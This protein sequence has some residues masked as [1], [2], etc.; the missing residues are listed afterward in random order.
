MLAGRRDPNLSRMEPVV[1]S[2]SLQDRYDILGQ[3]GSGG[4]G[5]VFKA[6]D[7]ALRR[8]V[9]IK[10]FG[11]EFGPA[12]SNDERAWREAMT[13]ASIQHPNILT[14]FDFGTDAEG[15]YVITEFLEGESLDAIV[16]RGGPLHMKEFRELVRQTLEGLIAAHQIGLIHRDIKPQNI[17]VTQLASGAL[18]FKILDF[19]LAKIL[20]EPK[21]QTMAGNQTIVGSIFYISPEQLSRHPVDERSDL[22]A[23]GCVYYFAL[24]GTQ[25]FDGNSIT[26]IITSHVRN[27]VTPLHQ[28]RPDMQQPMCDWVMKFIQLLPEHRFQNAVEA[29]GS[30]QRLPVTKTI[31][32]STKSSPIRMPDTQELSRMAPAAAAAAEPE[33]SRPKKKANRLPAILSSVALVLIVAAIGVQRIAAGRKKRAT[34]APAPQAV[35]QPVAAKPAASPPLAQPVAAKPV[36]AK[37]VASSQPVPVAQPAAPAFDPAEFAIT[38]EIVR[39]AETDRLLALVGQQAAVRGRVTNVRSRGE[40]VFIEFDG[41]DGKALSLSFPV[42]KEAKADAVK[43]ARGYKNQMV[44]VQGLVEKRDGA[45]VVRGRDL[46]Q[47][48]ILPPL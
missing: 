29:I 18:Q 23:M 43:R 36:A 1:P 14:V 20:Q 47:L 3:V 17:M 9:A 13:L 7:K 2:S 24:T 33:P 40:E 42:T 41:V 38:A 34:A 44:C 35:A 5:K 37:P 45:I 16:D 28:M 21:V 19:G 6:W 31:T 8:N 46:R 10:R 4:A 12:N 25:A 27:R 11:A 39:A 30:F 48:D 22:Y 32:I 15:P 26:E